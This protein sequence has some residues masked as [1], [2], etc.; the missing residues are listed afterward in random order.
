MI[1]NVLLVVLLILVAA[2]AMA[3]VPVPFSSG[4]ERFVILANGRFEKLEP[5]PPELVHAMEGQVV[6]RDHQGQ[7]KLFI[8][9]GRRLHL[10]DYRGA[11]VRGTRN[12]IAWLN[13]DTLKTIRSGRA[14]ALAAHVA[15]FGVS[16]SLVVLHD[17]L[18]HELRVIWRGVAY[19]VAQIERGSERPQWLLGSNALVIF[20]KEARKLSLFQ[21]GR[22]RTLS[23]STDVG[24]AVSGGDAVGWWDGHARVFKVLHKGKEHE[25]SD[26]RPASAKA[27]DG[28]IAYVDG[29]G[30][31]KCFDR[32]V[33]HRVLDEPPTEYW[34]KDSLLLYLEKGR[35]M[36]FRDGTS[37]LVEPYVPESWQVEGGLLAYLDLNRE[38]RGIRNGQRFRYGNEAAIKRFE[39]YGDRVVYRSPLG[40]MVVTSGRKSWI[41]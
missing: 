1:R 4:E 12:R 13:D 37:M 21:G 41:Y 38:L 40:Q 15:D 26:L 23:D 22:L 34:V 29:N 20:N 25:V 9:E 11:L 2:R 39:L 17:T 28:L 35:L 33:V 8:A 14:F 31:L 36:L 30:R 27:G 18:L 7:L 32:G 16:D 3:Q 5:R 10:L 24:I 6:Y 19:P